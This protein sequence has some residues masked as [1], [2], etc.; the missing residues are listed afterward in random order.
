MSTRACR[1]WRV[2]PGWWEWDVRLGGC[3]C[4]GTTDT[5]R[6]AYDGAV[7]D[8]AWLTGAVR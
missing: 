7:G 3:R 6:K 8:L 4:T 5:W 1:V 2:A